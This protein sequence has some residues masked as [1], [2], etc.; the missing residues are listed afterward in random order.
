MPLLLLASALL[1][2]CQQAPVRVPVAES[3]GAY[4]PPEP[5]LHRLTEAQL[6]GALAAVFDVDVTA[7]LPGDT[8]LHGYAVVGGSELTWAPSELEQLEAVAWDL[9]DAW[10]PDATTAE[11]RLGCDLGGDPL[12]GEAGEDCIGGFVTELGRRAWRRPLSGDERDRMVDLY[13]AVR[14]AERDPALAVQAVLVATVL[15][16]AFLYRVEIGQAD[17]DHP[18]QRVLTD[19]ELATRLSFFLV[20]G[21]PDE[22]LLLAAEQ[23]RLDGPGLRTQAERLLDGAKGQEQLLSFFEQ[24]LDVDRLPLV[25]K[26]PDLYPEWDADMVESLR[27]ETR[28]IVRAVLLEDELGMDALLTTDLFW[29]DQNTMALYGI[30]GTGLS[31]GLVEW[32][33]HDRAGI[34]GRGAWLAVNANNSLTS[35]THRGKAVR[36]RLLCQDIPPPPPGV[37]TIEET[38]PDASLRDR[39]EQHMTDPTCAGCHQLMD[40]IG[41]G[42]EHM[43]AIGAW[44]KLDG[45]H[46]IDATGELDGVT[47]DGAGDLAWAL[48]DH[49]QLSE[50]TTRQL[51]RFAKGELE[52]TGEEA[53]IQELSVLLEEGGSVRELVL[54]VVAS[55]AFRRLS[56]PASGICDEALEG[57]TRP[58]EAACGEGKE[59]CVAGLW[60]GCTADP[61]APESCNGID[62]DCDGSVDQDLIR[63]CQADWG[64]GE[65]VCDDGGWSSCEGPLPPAEI[66]DGVDQ[67]GDGVIDEVPAVWAEV[68]STAELQAAQP[69]CDPEG[70]PDTDTCA[71]SAHRFCN[72]LGCGS[73]SGLELIDP[74][75]DLHGLFCLDDTAAVLHVGSYATL[76]THHEG[77]TQGSVYGPACNAAISR[78]CA[79]IGQVTG[80]GPV[81]HSGDAAYIICTPGA[82]TMGT[83]Y[84]TIVAYDAGCDGSGERMGPHCNQA[85]HGFCRAQ[86]FA[87]GHGPLENSGDDLAVACIGVAP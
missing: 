48:A 86:G 21:P 65:Q 71:S 14:G 20:D 28:E 74:V 47:F 4:T 63:P 44:R 53:A 79:S 68:A 85:I 5:R 12:S 75:D 19:W 25:S 54:E 11:S 64:P 66:C 18:G 32:T 84:S 2:S 30:E 59:T 45:V 82:S 27:T 16:P 23:G 17:P 49:P 43:D 6:R 37:P 22:A 69:S 73:V 81:E 35:P 1:L 61:G 80:Y 56:A 72:S 58:C 39:L 3:A 7:D 83:T 15:D 87:T 70:A 62:D 78:Y 26:D 41:F 51:L 42:F 9:A 40:P 46:P 33:D 76:S 31:T 38:D 34:L 67:D 29:L 13:S 24:T 60:T 52:T 57:R 50:C 10:A 8:E 77:C 36:T 55:D